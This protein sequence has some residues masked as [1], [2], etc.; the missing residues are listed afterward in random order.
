MKEK[1]NMGRNWKKE[2]NDSSC[3]IDRRMCK[4]DNHGRRG[5]NILEKKPD[6]GRD[7]MHAGMSI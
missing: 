1:E 5:G 7:N 2:S 3:I 6:I 4:R